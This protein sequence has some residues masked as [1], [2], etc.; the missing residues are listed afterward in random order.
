MQAPNPQDALWDP[1]DN[2]YDQGAYER[3]CHEFKVSQNI[4]GLTFRSLQDLSQ[5][6]N[7]ILPKLRKVLLGSKRQA[8]NI[9]RFEVW[10]L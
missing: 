6:Q 2:P 1:F 4:R 10:S 9:L 8:P 3:I 5:R 7:D